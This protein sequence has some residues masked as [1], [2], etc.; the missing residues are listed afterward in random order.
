M[1]KKRPGNIY[2]HRLREARNSY[3]FSLTELGI[4]VG[5]DQSMASG[6]ISRYENG[7]HQPKLG[8]Q[9]L[10]ANVLE[11]PLAYFYTEDDEAARHIADS[12]RS[13]KPVHLL[14]EIKKRR[15][16]K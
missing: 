12:A 13:D 7:I 14:I 9:H 3:G 5:L 6:R 16:R 1:T 10:F 11:L 15:K 8:L 2:G 4:A